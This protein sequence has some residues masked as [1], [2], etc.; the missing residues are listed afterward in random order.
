MGGAKLRGAGE[1]SDIWC[2]GGAVD[3][4]N[5]LGKPPNTPANGVE[6]TSVTGEHGR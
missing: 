1:G 3:T 5:W 2:K 6:Y 4:P